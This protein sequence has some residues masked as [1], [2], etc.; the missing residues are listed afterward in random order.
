[1][2]ILAIYYHN[3]NTNNTVIYVQ[4]LGPFSLSMYE[5][6]FGVFLSIS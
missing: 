3:N 4:V 5:A 2:Y 1:M 6:I